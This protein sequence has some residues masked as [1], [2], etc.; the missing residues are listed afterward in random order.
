MALSRR[1]SIAAV[2]CNRGVVDMSA[3]LNLAPAYG[4]PQ[5]TSQ[6]T[7]TNW[8]CRVTIRSMILDVAVSLSTSRDH[9]V[10]PG[11]HTTSV[12]GAAEAVAA[13]ATHFKATGTALALQGFAALQ[14]IA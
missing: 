14:P 9:L 10:E 8:E 2:E 5:V 12:F 13:A 6:G 3:L 1:I 4:S 7:L 11:R